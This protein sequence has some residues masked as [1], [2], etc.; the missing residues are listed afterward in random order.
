MVPTQRHRRFEGHAFEGIPDCSDPAT[1]DIKWRFPA[2]RNP[3]GGVLA[4]AGGLAFLGDYAANFI[5]FDGKK[6][7]VLWRFQTGAAIFAAPIAYTFEGKQY[8]A[9]AACGSIIVFGL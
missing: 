2:S 4:T 3:S 5:A 9:V 1:G 6:G 8:I 7:T